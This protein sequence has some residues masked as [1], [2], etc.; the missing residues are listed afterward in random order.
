[1]NLNILELHVLSVSVT[2]SLITMV[3]KLNLECFKEKYIFY[4]NSLNKRVGMTQG[5]DF[6]HFSKPLHSPSTSN[7]IQSILDRAPPHGSIRQL[8]FLKISPRKRREHFQREKQK[9]KRVKCPPLNESPQQ[10]QYGVLTGQPQGHI[11][12][13]RV[14]T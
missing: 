4:Q 10:W 7:Y 5:P 12:Y 6:F 2:T 13:V 11:L 9:Q 3:R 1:M 8:Q 14:R